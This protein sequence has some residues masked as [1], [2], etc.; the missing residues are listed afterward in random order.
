MTK[1]RILILGAGLSGLSA[2][3]HLQRLNKECL[4]FEKE[5]ECGGLCRSKTMSGFTFDYCG[6]LLHFR[7][8][9]ALDLIRNLFQENLIEHKKSAWVY[10]YNRFTRYPFQANLFGL[11]RPVIKECLS[12]FIDA[13]RNLPHK[14]KHGFSFLEWMHLTFGKGIARHF[15][16]PYNQKFWTVDCK[17]LTCDWFGGFIPRP[18]LKEIIS[19]ALRENKKVF[20]YNA[21]FWYPKQ[22]G[23][24]EVSKAFSAKVKHLYLGY[25]AE[26]L[27]F[28]KR[29][30][31]FKNGRR[32]R[33]DALILTL[34][35]PEIAA[36]GKNLPSGVRGAL[37]NLKYNSIFNL[38][39]GISGNGTPDKHWVYFPE[40]K[41]VFFRAG[42]PKNFSASLAPPGASSVY[43]EVSYSGEK[44][45]DKKRIGGKIINGL[46]HAKV[47][48]PKD[49]ILIQDSND[50]KYGY[51][52]YD[53]LRAPSLKSINGYLRKQ[54]VF[55]LGR[56]GAWSYKSMEDCLL[57]GKQIAESFA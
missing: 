22:G 52:I 53:R 13:Q 19:G 39:L 7:S 26:S 5:A 37:K 34:P 4:V 54:R 14:A 21:A 18:T 36:L 48:K 25:E 20:G 15:M 27:D 38:N 30:V 43:A 23:I 3:W 10:S 46:K 33:Y 45:L 50:I 44:P 57:D 42:F 55:P 6:H 32:Y 9:Y 24:Q 29:E 12:G 31:S 41:F 1:E 49:K 8:A 40:K 17:E 56:Y 28:K 16:V 51:I 47:I 2:A 35:L 11:P